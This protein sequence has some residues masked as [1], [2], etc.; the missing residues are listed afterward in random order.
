[1]VLLLLDPTRPL[2]PIFVLCGVA[3]GLA[4]MP[5]WLPPE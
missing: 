2:L 4:I 5:R 1:V 3:M